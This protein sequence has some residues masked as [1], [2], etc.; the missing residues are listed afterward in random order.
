VLEE[1]A[2][3]QLA[4]HLYA[5]AEAT[6][7]HLIAMAPG[8]PVSYNT[9]GRVRL[10]RRRLEGAEAD[11]RTALSLAPDE[12]VFMNNL[13]LALHRMGK[14]KEAVEMFSR[15]AI[16]DPSFKPARQNFRLLA[17]RYLWGGGL[18]VVASILLHAIYVGIRGTPTAWK[19]AAVV[20]GIAT[21]VLV[22]VAV[23]YWLR[24]RALSRISRKLYDVESRHSRWQ[25]SRSTVVKAVGFLVF[26][27]AFVVALKANQ[28]FLAGIAFCLRGRLAPPK[29]LDVAP[30]RPP[31]QSPGTNPVAAPGRGSLDTGMTV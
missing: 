23:R 5:E 17:G 31:G 27:A 22:V 18:V 2:S 25:V 19:A 9:R 24:R 6:A 21:L 7:D 20:G 14:E 8:W 16:A 11:F 10:K 1:L 4:L 3:Q 29:L 26:T 12:A 13:G 30:G 28:Y 15:A